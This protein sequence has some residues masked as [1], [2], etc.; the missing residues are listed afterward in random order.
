MREA[1][2]LICVYTLAVSLLYTVVWITN[3]DAADALVI[4]FVGLLL[5]PSIFCEWK[6]V[7]GKS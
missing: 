2:V 4:F 5:F 7:R 1:I 6:R 3:K